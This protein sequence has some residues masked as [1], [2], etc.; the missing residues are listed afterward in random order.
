MATTKLSSEVSGRRSAV[1]RYTVNQRLLLISVVCLAIG[2]SVA[3]LGYR[4]QLRRTANAFL[5]RAEEF[6]KAGDTGQATA[7]YQRYLAVKPDDTEALIKMVKAYSQGKPNPNRF[8]RLTNLL[9]QALG[10]APDRHDLRLMLAENLLKT[11]AFEDAETEATKLLDRAPEHERTAGKVIAISKFV[12]SRIEGGAPHL[13]S[14]RGL[15]AAAA[16]LPGDVELIDVTAH[17][18]RENP[19]AVDDGDID[20]AT[21][22]DQL[23]D[24]LI[25]ANPNNTAAR[26]TRYRYRTYYKLADADADL[27]T[28]LE[29][30]PR[31][32]EALLLSA[33]SA[34]EVA[35]TAEQRAQAEAALRSV[36]EIAPD[37]PRGYLLLAM[38]LEQS[39]RREEALKLLQ[40]G[41]GITQNNFDLG[42]A[43]AH[44]QIGAGQM[45]A[46]KETLKALDAESASYL[47][48]LDAAE[49]AQADRQLRLLH[50][51]MDL[52]E[53]K[54]RSAISDLQSIF[55]L[56]ENSPGQQSSSEWL[57][58]SRLLAATYANQNQWDKASE[59]WERIATVLPGELD[60]VLSTIQAL[61]KSGR[62]QD[63]IERMDD[64][65]RLGKPNPDLLVRRAQAHLAL[66][67]QRVPEEQNWT[68]FVSA[69]KTAKSATTRRWELVFA[70]MEYLLAEA[71][72]NK[73]AIAF[74]RSA[75]RDFP[76]NVNFWQNAIQAYQVLGQSEDAERALA[77]HR[78]LAATPLEHAKIQATYFVRN[79]EFKQADDLLAQLEPTLTPPEQREIERLRIQILAAADKLDQA[80]ARAKQRIEADPKDMEMVALGTDIALGLGD[81]TAAENWETMLRKGTDD[82]LIGRVFTARRLLL[83]FEKLDNAGQQELERVLSEIRAERPQ[84]YPII[85]LEARHAELRG[86]M[87]K[88]L[89]DYQ[90]AVSRGDRRPFTLQQAAT[91]LIESNQFDEAQR[92]LAML[93]EE[94][95]GNGFLDSMAMEIA[96]KQDRPGMAL[97]LARK[98]VEKFPEDPIR[99][100]YLANLLFRNAKPSEAVEVLQVAS[101]KFGDDPRVWNGL[102][103]GLYQT[104]KIDELRTVLATL[105]THPELPPESRHLA[106]AQGYEML[107]DIV[108]AAK[109]YEMALKLQPTETAIRLKFAKLLAG[110][111]SRAAIGQLERLLQQEPNNLEAQRELAVVLAST[112]RE[113]DWTRANELLASASQL[114]TGD[115]STNDRLR[116]LLLSRKGRTRA[117]RLANCQ[118]ARSILGNLADA[119]SV[120]DSD[121]NELLLAQIFEQEAALSGDDALLVEADKAY[122][123]VV[124]RGS[125]NAARLSQYIEFLLRHGLGEGAPSSSSGSAV[126]DEASGSQPA[127]EQATENP[128]ATGSGTELR[129]TFL[130]AAEMRLKEL[131][132]LPP[133]SVDGL[134]AL[135]TALNAGLLQARGLSS[136]A[137][138][139]I[140]Q[141][142]SRATP[143]SADA[144]RQVQQYLTN[145]RLYTSIGAHAE[146]EVWYRKLLEIS[147]NAYGLLVQNL[148]E[149]GKRKEAAQ[150]CLEI[151]NGKPNA[152]IAAL[153]AVIMTSTDGEVEGLAEVQPAIDAALKEHSE[154]TALM[155][156]EAV[157][158][159]SRGEYDQAIKIFRRVV[160][161]EP[162]NALALNNL[163]TLLAEKPN[164][165]SE[166]L[167]HIEHAMEVAGRQGSLLDT[168]GTI[169]LKLGD[170]T[171]AIAC[172][173]EATAGEATDSRYYLHLAAAYQQA[174]RNDEALRMLK[175][176]KAFGLEKF[177]LTEDD[178]QMLVQ[179]EKML[180]PLPSTAETP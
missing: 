122:R 55:L 110:S 31:N 96:V 39:E 159:A 18:L 51:R 56:S 91:L 127:P 128:P 98:S 29:R 26:I 158:R 50:A 165:R 99:H 4:L 9:Y 174:E 142:V 109:Q 42:L 6:E 58:A 101:Q 36:L 171:Q 179:L 118:A 139:S 53:G 150:L 177:V 123:S 28:V 46:A 138:A 97:E 149:Q 95:P 114:P 175:E 17:A 81:L 14:I 47:V 66:Q 57:Q 144:N 86:D 100:L 111:D 24:R 63:A 22:A 3:Y 146:A 65:L 134:D 168:Q 59:Y 88:A 180:T 93:S 148:V 162:D 12:R 153:L 105:V 85:A 112:G 119:G 49:R 156:A 141:F 92:Y 90:L 84:W 151:S 147:P 172:L 32:I 163:A 121:L 169:L 70:E 54:M 15:M 89:A 125:P 37:E 25:A 136:E 103:S 106:V 2:L 60:V 1:R 102:V 40:E 62:F 107:G 34:S 79:Q 164:L 176:S 73:A 133:G 137:L 44:L 27:K 87:N 145:G 161:L 19:S 74:L 113:A 13:E 120:A 8:A 77:R 178:R 10:R 80:F 170:A 67:S 166:A 76:D 71:K 83:G 131:G 160:E 157:K 21:R 124:D 16:E 75:E 30:E 117:E 108:S 11:G 72:D 68:E 173:E 45:D 130:A 35:A 143:A 115:P 126:P 20:A 82:G 43:L 104:G 7:Y 129:E 23:M 64:Y 52:A 78:K 38:I 94:Q 69:L 132:S 5:T 167:K 155:Q 152:E 116:A 154:N 135:V 41:R 140:T 48:R 33:A 61:L